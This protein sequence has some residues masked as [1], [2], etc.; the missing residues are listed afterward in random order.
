MHPHRS[1]L[2]LSLA[3]T[4]AACGAVDKVLE[5][6]VP[7]NAR[8]AVELPAGALSVARGTSYQFDATITR[9]G[10]YSG[11]VQFIVDNGPTGIT[12]SIGP[13]TTVGQ[14][15]TATVTLTVDP[16]L[17]VGSYTMRVMG[18][19]SKI[20]DVARVL[21]INVLPEPSYD[22][23]L[24]RQNVTVVKGGIAPL[25]L[26]VSRTN[27]SAPIALSIEAAPGITASFTESP[28]TGSAAGV[29][30]VASSDVAPGTYEV[31]L[32]GEAE[33][34][35]AREVTLTVVVIADALQLITEASTARQGTSITTPVVINRNGFEEPVSLSVANLPAGVT[36]TFDPNPAAG[37]SANMTLAV[38][39][40]VNA[41]SYTGTVNASTDGSVI[42]SAEFSLTVTPSSLALALTPATVSLFQGTN[43]TTKL[44]FTRTSLEAPVAI[45]FGG[46][47]AGV[48]ASA[49]PALVTGN[50]TTITVTVGASAVPGDYV[51]SVQAVPQGWQ[52]LGSPSVTLPLTVRPVP[53][54]DGNVILDWSRC[55]APLWVAKQDGVG[56]WSQVAASSGGVFRFTIVEA[57]AGF[58]YVDGDGV[59]VQYMT[60]AQLTSAPID[61]CPPPLSIGTKTVTGTGGHVGLGEVFTYSLGGRTTTSTTATP[62]F[63]L[64]G[65]PDGVHDFV[66]FGSPTIT[67]PRGL[68]RRD[69]DVTDGESFGS[70]DLV[71]TEAFAPLRPNVTQTGAFQAGDVLAHSMSYLTTPACTENLL[72][73]TGPTGT[74]TVMMGVPDT[75]QRAT[76]FHKITSTVVGTSRTRIATLV[77]NRM[78]ARTVSLPP[79][80]GTPQVTSL[81]GG[82]RRLQI[83]VGSV[84]TAYNRIAEFKYSTGLKNMTIRAT[85]QYIGSGLV[86]L[87]MPSFTGISGWDDA[88]A[89]P[90]SASG[91]YTFITDGSNNPS[92]PVCTEGRSTVLSRQFGTF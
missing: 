8:L 61:M 35:D 84:S 59:T 48:T 55:T 75:K 72:Y 31:T 33:G 21:N 22:L 17:P 23:S 38:A 11:P 69:L 86:N 83:V 20:P 32:L 1:L 82:Y 30:I 52:T 91:S 50:E 25:T 39:P 73:A 44:S 41:Q 10:D 27:F 47:P 54:T 89:I 68:I 49:S 78:Q 19:A 66:A 26:S 16:S 28:L 6:N 62:N 5:G 87:V 57:R 64:T 74:V 67:G 92:A 13:Q 18:R 42:A 51:V 40:F 58:A 15:S 24:S 63:Q 71:G 88:Y 85:M 34:L 37:G 7:P 12:A 80:N 2:F 60:N 36:A 14:A 3:A 76:D 81:T 90:A 53:G 46:L 9:V 4:I 77:F 65:V 45:S 70:I 29:T 79:L 56:G 43:T